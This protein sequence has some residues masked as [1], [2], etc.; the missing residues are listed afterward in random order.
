MTKKY[1]SFVCFNCVPVKEE[2]KEIVTYQEENIVD[3]IKRDVKACE[4]SSKRWK[5]DGRFKNKKKCKKDKS[6]FHEQKNSMITSLPTPQSCEDCED[7]QEGDFTSNESP[8][9]T[10]FCKEKRFIEANRVLRNCKPIK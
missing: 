10:L 1:R 6:G 4:A 5:Q 7:H 2:L 3:R 9:Q 8:N